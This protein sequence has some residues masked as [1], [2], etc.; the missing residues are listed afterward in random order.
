[1]INSSKLEVT[2]KIRNISSSR[3]GGVGEVIS[4]NDLKTDLLGISAFVPFTARGEVVKAKVEKREKKFLKTKLLEVIEPSSKRCNPRCKVFKK[5]GGCELQHLE[6]EEER[7]SKF[8]MIK[9]A[10]R[11]S[12]CDL[13]II[14][15]LKPLVGGNEYGYR[16]RVNLHIDSKG[17]VGFFRQKSTV[18]EKITNCPIVTDEINEL[19]ENIQSFGSR[20]CGRITSILLESDKDGVIAVLRTPYDLHKS[21]INRILEVSKDYFLNAFIYSLNKEVGGYGRNQIELLLKENSSLI[22]KVPVG[23]FTQVNWEVNQK[24]IKRVLAFV[25]KEEYKSVLDLYSGAGNFSLP[26]ASL[27]LKVIAVEC[28][29]V[30]VSGGNRSVDNLNLNKFLTFKKMSVEK[31][32]RRFN[33]LTFDVII[34]DPPRSGLGSLVTLLPKAKR[35]IVVYCSL[36]SF[37]RDLKKIS[38]IGWKL[39]TIEPFDMFSRTSYI[40]TLAVFDRE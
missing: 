15:S 30:L 29:K 12:R 3:G 34:A 20:V 22:L 4:Q 13:E 6:I 40:E 31:Y 21:E 32:L 11:A 26:L 27:R 17:N 7:E 37:I 33:K 18:V 38:Q 5:C 1:M 16:R 28:D 23:S 24:L 10:L 36:P 19:L 39:K 35:L 14:D 2:V 8:E 25:N 9:G